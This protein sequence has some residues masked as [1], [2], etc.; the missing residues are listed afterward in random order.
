MVSN[1]TLKSS[2]SMSCLPSVL[3]CLPLV[4]AAVAVAAQPAAAQ[5]VPV[6]ETF[7]ATTVNIDPAE[8]GLRFSVLR[9][10][11]EADRQAVVDVLTSP[12]AEAGGTDG[13][14]ADLL[15][16]P[17]LGHLWLDSSSV[18]YSLKYAR[19]VPLAG[20]GENVTFVTGRRVGTFGRASWMPDGAAADTPTRPFT[21]IELRIDHMNEGEGKLSAAADISIDTNR[22]LVGLQDYAAAPVVLESVTRQPLPYW[23]R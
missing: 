7:T 1:P 6:P 18:G 5:E 21:V 15:E 14:L 22:S 11:G 17:S 12:E 13:E 3:G 2:K 23:A 9:W 4:V 20:G 16:L 10:S 8:E 19:R